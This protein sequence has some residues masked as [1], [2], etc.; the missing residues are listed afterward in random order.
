MTVASFVARPH[1][2]CTIGAGTARSGWEGG[3]SLGCVKWR[4]NR[5]VEAST[6]P[7]T[8]GPAPS[9]FGL[10]HGKRERA[11]RSRCAEWPRLAGDRSLHALVAP[12]NRADCGLALHA[13][14][15]A[16]MQDTPAH[17]SSG[18]QKPQNILSPVPA[19]N[20]PDPAPGRIGRSPPAGYFPSSGSRPWRSLVRAPP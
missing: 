20:P 10:T 17:S 1:L 5:L 3:R 2:A 18:M 15:P 19:A 7:P 9:R 12:S 4:V 13:P 11:R 8:A 14:L 6:I 16:R